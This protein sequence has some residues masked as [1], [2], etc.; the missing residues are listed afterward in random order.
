M[1]KVGVDNFICSIDYYILRKFRKKNVISTEVEEYFQKF[2]E[3][4]NR[5]PALEFSKLSNCIVKL[6][7]NKNDEEKISL[8]LREYVGDTVP[9]SI[10]GDLLGR[11]EEML[12]SGFR[13][14]ALATSC[15]LFE[16]ILEARAFDDYYPFDE[17]TEESASSSLLFDFIKYILAMLKLYYR[18]R[19]ITSGDEI[20]ELKRLIRNDINKNLT[21]TN[22]LDDTERDLLCYILPNYSALKYS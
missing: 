1:K 4:Y 18:D 2:S 16:I 15:Q 14:V 22:Q 19:K 12:E 5:D 17:T 11:Y 8:T 6:V 9:E 7:L 3:R 10:I 21:F 20:A 13:E